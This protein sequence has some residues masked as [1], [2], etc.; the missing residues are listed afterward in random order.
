MTLSGNTFATIRD[1]LAA[2]PMTRFVAFGPSTS[3]LGFHLKSRIWN[4]MG[5]T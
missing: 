3:A 5:L 1:R 2:Q 4:N